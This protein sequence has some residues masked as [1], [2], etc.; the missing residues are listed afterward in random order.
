MSDSQKVVVLRG[1]LEEI[2]E[3]C[4]SDDQWHTPART[5]IEWMKKCWALIQSIA[6]RALRDTE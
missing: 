5:T 4:Y 1:A 3:K 2:R 6:A